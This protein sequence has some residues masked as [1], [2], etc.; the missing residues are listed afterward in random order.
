MYH[1]CTGI[2]NRASDI[3][4]KRDKKIFFLQHRYLTAFR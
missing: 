1:P 2:T 4:R 3:F